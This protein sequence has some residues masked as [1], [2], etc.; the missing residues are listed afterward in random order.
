[1]LPTKSGQTWRPVTTT[2]PP[3]PRPPSR[4]VHAR[5]LLR[6][7]GHGGLGLLWPHSAARQPPLPAPRPRTPRQRGGMQRGAACAAGFIVSPQAPLPLLSPPPPPL[8][9][10]ASPRSSC[11]PRTRFRHPPPRLPGVSQAR[12][13]ACR[14]LRA[15]RRSRR[16]RALAGAGHGWRRSRGRGQAPAQRFGSRPGRVHEFGSRPGRV[17]KQRV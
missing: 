14:A 11:L 13:Q 3:P 17:H 9:R 2:T 16:G 1:M 15:E 8:L 7:F 4:I 10:A 5:R 12:P 6:P